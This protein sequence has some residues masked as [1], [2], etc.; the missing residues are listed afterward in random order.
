[1]NYSHLSKISAQLPPQPRFFRLRKLICQNRLVRFLA[2]NAALVDSI[3]NEKDETQKTIARANTQQ[4]HQAANF[5]S[6]YGYDDDVMEV[7]VAIRYKNEIANK[8][9]PTSDSPYLYDLAIKTVSHL[10]ST[11]AVKSVLNFGVCYAH[12]D[13]MLARSY[14]QTPFFGVD[15]SLLTQALNK[16]EFGG[17]GNM[18]FLAADIRDVLKDVVFEDGCLLHMRTAIYL[19]KPFVADVYKLAAKA[20]F[21]RI[22]CIEPI[23]LSR[24][25]LKPYEFSE[26]DQPSVVLRGRLLIHNYVGLL[27]AAGYTI[28]SAELIKMAHPHPDIRTLCI[29][30][31]LRG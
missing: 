25:T 13:S 5:G 2:A 10:I 23:G 11:G 6:G 7:S 9:D 18:T 14:P 17:L 24:Q 15:R 27:K 30:A 19:P 31:S 21:K 16:A 12:T 29:V 3:E 4:Q 20:K 1:M 22:V 28:D 8:S 26:S